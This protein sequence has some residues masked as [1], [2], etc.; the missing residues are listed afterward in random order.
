M[1]VETERKFLVTGSFREC[2]TSTYHIVQGYLCRDATRSV[3]V[4]IRNTEAF[5]TI[6]GPSSPDGL[7]RFEWEQRLDPKDAYKMLAFCLPGVVDKHRYLV[8]Y[9]GH[10]FE[11]D[12][13]HG[14]N[15]G[16]VIA[17]VELSDANEEVLLPPFLGKEVTGDERYYNARLSVCP[18]SEWKKEDNKDASH[19]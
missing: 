1:S 18:F 8:P 13:F 6:K 14:G 7:S 3:R 2:V 9:E 11:V 16:L 5:L 17:E 19:F 4:R 10:V 12:E 15:E